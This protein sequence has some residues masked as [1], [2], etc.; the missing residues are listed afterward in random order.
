VK[1]SAASKS[2]GLAPSTAAVIFIF[3]LVAA[4][5]GAGPASSALVTLEDTDDDATVIL[6]VLDQ[7]VIGAPGWC[8]V[9]IVVTEDSVGL[10]AGD[11]VTVE[12]VEFDLA[13]SDV[14][15][16]ATSR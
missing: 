2:R 9:R 4:L 8:Q 11:S 5:F 1:S 10:T 16:A 14:F 3:S 12:A 6:L 7:V 15:F 13:D